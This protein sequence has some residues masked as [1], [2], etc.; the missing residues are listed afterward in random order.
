MEFRTVLALKP[1]DFPKIS[2]QSPVLSIGS[3]FAE[4]IGLRLAETKFAVQPQ[5]L[6]TLFNPL[7]IFKLLDKKAIQQDWT[8]GL[9][10]NA[11]GVWHHYDFHSSLTALQAEALLQDIT[12]RLQSL[13]TAWQ[14]THTLILTF[15]TAWVYTLQGQIVANCHKMPSKLFEK[16]LLGVEEIIRHFERIYEK[17]KTY[18]LTVSPVRHLKEG[19]PQ[20]QVSKSVL[21]LACHLLAERY[22]NVY[23]FPAYE[24]LLDDLRDY[25]FYEADMLHP[26]VQAENYIWERFLEVCTD[27]HTRSIVQQWQRLRQSLAHRPFQPQSQAHR[28]FLEK[29]LQDLEAL[30]TQLPLEEEIASLKV[31]LAELEAK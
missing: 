8:Q 6:G 14:K 21:R 17:D 22:P 23:Y 27:A 3:C 2:L 18:L 12:L 30:A 20:N 16:R 7:S 31:R 1:N 15:G 11:E 28:H 5:A 25:R 24:L 19:L 10:Q 13:Q 29:L 4:R 26:N 9:C